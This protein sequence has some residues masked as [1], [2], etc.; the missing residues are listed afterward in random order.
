MSLTPLRSTAMPAAGELHALVDDLW[1]RI[2]RALDGTWPPWSLPMLVTVATDGPRARVLALR[3]AD[4]ATRTFVFHADARSDKVREIGADPRVSVVFW[5]A[6]DG[7]EARFTGKAVLHRGDER[8]AC[9]AWERVSP[10]RRHASRS[11]GAPGSMLRE[12][13]RFE[14]L[15]VQEAD[16]SANFAVIEVEATRLDWLWVGADDMRRALF[17]WTGAGW[18]GAWT[19]P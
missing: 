4:R 17:A 10:L 9:A 5:D 1:N 15:P 14:A 8:V 19:V 18:D 6:S 16:G 13:T 12:P 11:A 7:I 2:A 3:A